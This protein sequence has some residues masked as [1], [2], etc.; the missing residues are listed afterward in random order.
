[1][2]LYPYL[3]KAKSIVYTRFIAL[4]YSIHVG[5]N[6]LFI[7]KADIE[8][9]GNIRIG[10]DCVL[11]PWIVLRERG[12]HIHIGDNCSVNSF[13][14]ISGNGGVEIGNNVRIA[15]QC[16]II[17]ANH[18]YSDPNTPIV[19]Q[20]ETRAKIV[21]DDDC[22]LGAGVKVLAGVHIGEG[23]VIGAGAVVTHDIEPYSVAVGIPAKVIKKRH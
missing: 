13:C 16:V 9:K 11:Y 14:H 3:A 20:G 1:M 4:R 6:S 15:T 5:S 19:F 2:K 23:C 12:G 10:K 8:S 22:W 17:S 18:N 7:G 21:I